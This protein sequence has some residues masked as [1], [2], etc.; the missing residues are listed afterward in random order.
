MRIYK[1]RGLNPDESYACRRMA[2]RKCFE[3]QD[4]S[5]LWGAS[6]DFSFDT[7]F[8]RKPK[9]NGTV[10]ASL[11]RSRQAQPAVLGF[12]IISNSAYGERQKKLFEEGC[13][14]RM[15]EWLS[16]ESHSSGSSDQLLVAWTGSSFC[17]H[18]LHFS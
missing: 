7:R 5:V 10:V 17:I 1:P 15:R 11:T 4:I 2:V 3:G 6:K 12:Y 14:P 13:L 9:I 16:A 18:E 8:R